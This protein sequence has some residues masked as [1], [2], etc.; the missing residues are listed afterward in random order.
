MD[1]R[2]L[3]RKAGIDLS[4]FIPRSLVVGGRFFATTLLTFLISVIFAR[5]APRE[6]YGQYQY[7]LSLT[8]LLSVL[9]LPGL[10]TAALR[11]F[12]EGDEG[13]VA[14]SVYYSF[15]ASLMAAAALVAIGAWQMLHHQ[16]SL[17]LA[18]IVAGLLVPA[19]YAPNNWYIYY[20][21]KSDFLGSTYRMV[22]ANIIL[23]ISMT[24]GLWAHVPL[25]GLVSLF[26]GSNAILITLFYLEGKR[27]AHPTEGRSRLSLPYAFRCTIQK[28]TATLGENLQTIAI[29]SV[30]GFANLAIYQ[31][32]QS[33]VNAFIGL[34]GALSAIYFPLLVKYKKL[35]HGVIVLQ[36]L[37]VGAVFLGIYLVGVRYLFAP[38]YGIKYHDAIILAY[39]LSWIVVILPLRVYLNNFFSIRDKNS[40]VIWT[41]LTASGV[42]LAVFFA[43][44]HSGFF[45]A[46]TLYLYI[47]NYLMVIPLLVLYLSPLHHNAPAD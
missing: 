12:V 27:R 10:N 22:T 2:S 41:N 13:A 42:A 44:R 20:E 36:H 4:Y 31:V 32:A 23:L 21:G 40:Y 45:P 19:Y 17:G 15:R 3:S 9:S 37:V 26:L 43:S 8:S 46:A 7:V 14:K 30:F 35:N 1:L 6:I 18:I 29:S 33:M 25:V 47:S 38:L 11:A 24:L 34:T 16:P 28:F 39:K 5:L